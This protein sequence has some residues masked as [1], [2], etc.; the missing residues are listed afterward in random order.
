[1]PNRTGTH[2]FNWGRTVS[3]SGRGT[4][5]PVESTV[6]PVAICDV[7]ECL[8]IALAHA[9]LKALW[10]NQEQRLLLLLRA[11]PRCHTQRMHA[12]Y[13]FPTVRTHVE[14]PPA[15]RGLWQRSMLGLLPGHFIAALP[16]SLTQPTVAHARA[17]CQ[18]RTVPLPP[19]SV[20]CSLMRAF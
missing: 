15:Y 6:K 17:C 7:F 3:T 8:Q 13:G 12:C 9:A 5:L 20:C 4:L 19:L 10:V 2:P 16:L 1:M 14:V 11:T 18:T